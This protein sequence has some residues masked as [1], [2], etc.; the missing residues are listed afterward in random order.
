MSSPIDTTFTGPL[1]RDEQTP[2]AWT[3]VV[4]PGSGEYFGTRRPVKVR[5]ELDGHP[6]AATLLPMGDGTHMVPVK[7]ALRE[8]LGKTDGDPVT[9]H[10]TERV[11]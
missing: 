6:F 8:P 11:G 5:G 3:I 7:A 10:L 9:V 4:M 1:S 2:G